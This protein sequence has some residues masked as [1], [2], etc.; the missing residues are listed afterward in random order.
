MLLVGN[1][2]N[3]RISAFKLSTGALKGQLRKADGKLIVNNGLWGIQ[4]GNGRTGTPRDLLFAAGI[5]DYLHGLF[6]LIHPN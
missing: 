5:D 4:F 3:G 2:D 6:G 1:V